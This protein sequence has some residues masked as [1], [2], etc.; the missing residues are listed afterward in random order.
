MCS[1][2]RP[3]VHGL[4]FG[5]CGQITLQK[6][7]CHWGL[8]VL[9]S[10]RSFVHHI[11]KFL[12][13]CW[14]ISWKDYHKIWHADISSRYRCRWILLSFY[15]PRQPSAP[16]GIDVGHCLHPSV[17]PERH[18]HSNSLRISA[19]S[20]KFGGW[21]TLTWSRLLYK[22][23][24]LSQFLRIPRHFE[25]SKIGQEQVRGRT[26]LLWLFLSFFEIFYDRL[27]PGR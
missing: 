10:V 21:C 16:T 17:R 2:V 22:M 23:V 14:Q 8:W 1:S 15:Y 5:Y 4:G 3:T 6:C 24:M 19:I 25:M 13:V 12:R 20:L 18:Y 9:L 26:L 11:L 7:G 27:W